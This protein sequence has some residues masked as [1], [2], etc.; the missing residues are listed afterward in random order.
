MNKHIEL[1]TYINMMSSMYPKKQKIIKTFMFAIVHSL[2]R[3][4][5]SLYVTGSIVEEIFK[6]AHVQRK[7]NI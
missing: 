5:A 7:K 3:Q 6:H 2:N 1:Q 4:S